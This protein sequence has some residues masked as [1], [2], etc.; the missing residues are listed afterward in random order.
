VRVRVWVAAACLAGLGCAAKKPVT[1]PLDLSGLDQADAA[2]LQGCYDCL[3]DAR[4]IYRR[5]GAGAGRPVVLTRLFETSLLLT[6]RHKEL[7]LDPSEPFGEAQALANELP[8]EIE[9]D[10]YL[11]LVDAVPGDDV[12]SPHRTIEAFRRARA[13]AGFVQKVNDELTW[14]K[15]GALREPVRDYLDLAV[16]C[17][18]PTRASAPGQPPRPTRPDVRQPPAGAP[19]LVAYRTAICLVLNQPV[20]YRL[21]DAEP[22]FV[23]ASLFLARFDVAVAEQMGPGR[24]VERLEE[25]RA[26]F[27]ASP[28]ATYLSGSINQAIGDCDAALAF[29]DETIALAP[30]H[31][32]ALLGR[33]ICLTFLKRPADAIQTATRMIDLE[34]DNISDAYYWRAWNRH[35][36]QELDL[37][38]ADIERA[39]RGSATFQIY[40]LAGV[41]EYDQNDLDPSQRDLQRARVMVSG[42]TNC[43][44]I[45]YLALV[46]TKRG[47]GWRRRASSRTPCRATSASPT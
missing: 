47:G 12:G 10:R 6:L 37:A 41:I 40:T 4:A 45:W 14:L 30:V 36:G 29:Y 27:P 28:S 35:A 15:T 22:R 1:R 8:P 34:T 43:E 16:D 33:T 31:E 42:D 26:R 38:R 18:Y 21:R 9:A 5:I 23:E 32:N 46:Q 17:A 2:V 11:A 20:L 7:A 3:L 13:E 44:A 39:K 25:A 24:A 19:P